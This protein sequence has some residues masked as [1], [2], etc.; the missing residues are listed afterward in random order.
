LRPRV[1]ILNP[2]FWIHISG[3]GTETGT[4]FRITPAGRLKYPCPMSD[5]PTSVEIELKI[6]VRDLDPTRH[7]LESAGAELLHPSEAELNLLLDN[8]AR[9]LTAADR[10]LRLRRI[11]GRQ[12]LTLKGPAAYHGLI[13]ERE[14]LELEVD[15]VDTLASVFEELGFYS[16]FR[17]EKERESWRLGQVTVALDHTPMGDFVEVEGPTGELHAVASR[18]GL[19]PET[20]VRGSYVSLWIEYRERRSDLDLPEDMVFRE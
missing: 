11:G 8:P 19:D 4:G 14:E 6:P 2:E 13:R 5:T 15:D 20:A 3:T 16:V 9:E 12:L 7:A 10:V 1:K 18:I 17:Y